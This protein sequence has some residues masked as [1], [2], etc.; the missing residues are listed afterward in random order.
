MADPEQGTPD[1]AKTMITRAKSAS[2]KA[3]PAKKKSAP[4]KYSNARIDDRD[5]Q[6][7]DSVLERWVRDHGLQQDLAEAGLQARWTDVVGAD[8]ADHVVPEGIREGD[9][10]RELLLRAD[11]TAWATQV[12]LLIPQ[13]ARR[14]ADEIGP[15]VIDRI[16]VRGPAPPRRDVGPRRVPGRGPRDTYG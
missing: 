9:A 8:L 14:I 12:S 2:R 10:G 5:P 13:I 15:G 16:I 3:A 1:L 4:A 11:S 6:S 7:V